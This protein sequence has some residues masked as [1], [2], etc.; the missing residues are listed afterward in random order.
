MK[1]Q[2]DGDKVPD[3]YMLQLQHYF[4]V[5]GAKWGYFAYL[6]GGNTFD[7]KFVERDEAVIDLLFQAE[8]DF[9]ELVK[10]QTPPDLDGSEGATQLLKQLFPVEDAQKETIE[11]G[12]EADGLINLYEAAKEVE[13][14]AKKDKAT[15]ENRLKQLM[16]NYEKAITPTGRK[17]SWSVCQPKKAKF[18]SEKFALAHPELYKEFSSLPEPYRRWGGIK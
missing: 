7:Y 11:L 10:N 5:T 12:E 16:G 2:W 4:A 3:Y 9:W 18:D 8:R 1:A 17:V 13:E 6:L 14:G 15:A